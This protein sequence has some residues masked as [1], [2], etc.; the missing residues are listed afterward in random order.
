MKK[1]FKFLLFIVILLGV[2][3]FFMM[4]DPIPLE[5]L[6]SKYTNEQSKF[7]DING[8]SVH[9]RDEGVGQPIVLVHG[10]GAALQT[11]D[12]WTDTLKQYYRV[13]RMDIP[14]FGLTGPN[15]ENDYSLESY[16]KFIQDFTQKLELKDF[17]LG[18]NSLGGEIAWKYAYYHPENVKG[19]LLLNPAG[20]PIQKYD[21]PFFSAFNLARIPVISSLLSDIDPK[22]TIEQTLKQ[23]YEN[24]ELITP[25]KVQMY[26]DLTMRDGNRKAFVR[27]MQQLDKDPVL[28]PEQ[29]E[30]PTLILWGK[31]D[32]LL[33]IEQLE[34]FRGMKNM[35]AIVYPGVGHTPQDEVAVQSVHDAIQF[36]N[37]LN[38]NQDSLSVLN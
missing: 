12:Q 29:V 2:G 16:V 14:A 33:L 6:K 22:F 36:I 28:Q 3:I 31:D 9:Y 8:L 26:Y 30:V 32:A 20:S 17:I 19:L 4:K 21:M 25:E 23:A 15:T 11:F 35:Q 1:L 13:I 37:S 34:G 38:S 18:G 5:V 24:D 7:I 27:R 10:T